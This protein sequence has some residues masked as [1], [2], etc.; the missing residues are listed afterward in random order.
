MEFESVTEKKA[1]ALLFFICWI[2][3]WKFASWG[4]RNNPRQDRMITVKHRENCRWTTCCGKI[5]LIELIISGVRKQWIHGIKSFWVKMRW[6]CHVSKRRACD[7]DELIDLVEIVSVSE[8]DMFSFRRVFGH[9][10]PACA[11]TFQKFAIAFAAITPTSNMSQSNGQ[12]PISQDFNVVFRHVSGT[13]TRF[14]LYL[15]TLDL[16]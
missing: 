2:S 10:I 15:T 12:W 13:R 14:Q 8:L 9:V 3:F 7:V 16:R 4:L 11:K 6:L 1:Q 5:G